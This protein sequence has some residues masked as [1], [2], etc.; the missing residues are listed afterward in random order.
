MQPLVDGDILLYEIGFAAETGWKAIKEWKKGDDPIDPPPFEYVAELLDNRIKGICVVVGATTDPI[1]YFTGKDNFREGIAKKKKY[2]DNRSESSR[3]FHYYNIK[4]YC[5]SK[6][7]CIVVEGMEADDALCI[8]QVMQDDDY[9]TRF[10]SGKEEGEQT[11]ICS[12]DKDLRQCPGWHFGWELG[13]Q[14]QFGPYLVDELGWIKLSDDRKKVR[15]VGSK[16]FHAQMLMGDAVD[17]IPG[18]PNCGPVATFNLI[19]PCTS[20]LE[21]EQAVVGAYKGVY[22]DSWKDELLEQAMLVWMVRELDEE[23]KPIM[24]KLIGDYNV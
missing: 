17:N 7:D 11:I 6:Y 18:L 2:K 3:P 20:T 24:Y 15:G 5:Q 23:G 8:K 12:R 4:V 14:P 9:I 13:N 21:C 16:F 10:V 19:N 22:E 1:L